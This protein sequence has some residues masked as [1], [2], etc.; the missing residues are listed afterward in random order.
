MEHEQN[1]FYELMGGEKM[2]EQIVNRFYSK[3]KQHPDLSPI[4]PEDLTVTRDKQK[5]FLTQ[6][7]GGPPL[8]LEKYGHPM[9]RARHMRFEITPMRAQAWLSCMNEALDEV[10]LEGNVRSA[11]FRRLT[12]IAHFMVNT[13]DS[14]G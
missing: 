10:G 3:V 4:F 11:F 12:E 13:P 9:M 8:Y 5:R 14:E 2:L 7:F 1:S 6:L